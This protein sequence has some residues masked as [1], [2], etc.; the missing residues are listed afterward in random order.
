MS[1]KGLAACHWLISGFRQIQGLAKCAAD[2]RLR[3]G[4]VSGAGAKNKIEGREKNV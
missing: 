2:T 3:A 1:L 4:W